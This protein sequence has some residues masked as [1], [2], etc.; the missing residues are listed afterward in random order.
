MVASWLTE[1]PS[2]K[3]NII[4]K[5]RNKTITFAALGAIAASVL[6]GASSCATDADVASQNLSTAAEQFEVQRRIIGINGITDKPAFM[7]EGRCSIEDE[8]HRLVVTCKHADNDYRKHF[9][10][11]SDNTFYVIEQLDGIDVSVYHTRILLKPENILPELDL[12][13]GKQ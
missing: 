10:G 9:V 11:L 12:E 6:L 7:V 4:S 2:N 8:G 5:N 1:I 13:T 3:E